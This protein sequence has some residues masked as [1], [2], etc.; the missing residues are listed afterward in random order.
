MA[1]A[2]FRILGL[3][4]FINIK[5]S[6]SMAWWPR[7][8]ARLVTSAAVPRFHG[9]IVQ[10]LMLDTF[11]TFQLHSLPS[12][13]SSTSLWWF[14]FSS[15]SRPY[16]W[17]T[18]YLP[19][20]RLRTYCITL[21]ELVTSELP[22]LLI[23]LHGFQVG[24]LVVD[25]FSRWTIAYRDV[26]GFARRP[27]WIQWPVMMLELL[28]QACCWCLMLIFKLFETFFDIRKFANCGFKIRRKLS[29]I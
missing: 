14:R 9:A 1:G 21:T 6:T 15:H 27:L 23:T 8:P 3:K 4:Y 20:T 29:L 2:N 24:A 7:T 12:W 25:S 22:S 17:F 19:P 13:S 18:R 26:L 16:V 11:T 5:I 28:L 10:I